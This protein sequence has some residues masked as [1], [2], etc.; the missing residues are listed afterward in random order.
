MSKLLTVRVRAIHTAPVTCQLHSTIRTPAQQKH[1]III[2]M[3]VSK[4]VNKSL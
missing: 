4:V 1:P 3:V 2:S